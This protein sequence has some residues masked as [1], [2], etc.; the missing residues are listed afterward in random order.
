[1]SYVLRR[2]M[3]R[4][5]GSADDGITSGLRPGYRHGES[6]EDQ[7]LRTRGLLQKYSPPK[8]SSMNDFLINFGLNMASNPPSGNILQTAATEAREPFRAFQSSR[9]AQDIEKKKINAALIGDIMAQRSEEHIAQ[10]EAGGKGA[11][12][13]TQIEEEQIKRA[14]MD[15]SDLRKAIKA[16]TDEESLRV[17]NA[18]LKGSIGVLTEILGVPIEYAAIIGDADSFDNFVE[19]AVE[20]ENKRRVNEYKTQNPDTT[21]SDIEEFVE[22]VSADSVEAIDLTFTFLKKKYGYQSGGRVGR[23]FGGP[24][25]E[26]QMRETVSTPRGSETIEDTMVE[27]APQ[28]PDSPV[29]NLSYEELRARLPQEIGDDIVRLLSESEQALIDFANI[30]TQQDI[31]AFNQKYQVELVLPAEA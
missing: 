22:L 7:F 3:F 23:Q 14:Y 16:E 8:R 15:I 1:M 24:M 12:K 21:T 30:Q 31:D 20:E 10:T 18:K 5:G 26:E 6:V 17:L 13:E 9:G 4:K 2:P 25:V 11:L 27:R 29:Q 19:V 28:N